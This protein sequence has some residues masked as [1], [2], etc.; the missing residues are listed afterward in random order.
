MPPAPSE[1]GGGRNESGTDDKDAHGVIS[2]FG[3]PQL[4]QLQSSQF[5]PGHSVGRS[6][7]ASPKPGPER[8]EHRNG[9]AKGQFRIG[10][11]K[12][13]G[14]ALGFRKESIISSCGCLVRFVTSRINCP[15][16]TIT[17]EEGL[18]GQRNGEAPAG[19]DP[20]RIELP[21]LPGLPMEW[22]SQFML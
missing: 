16:E 14:A 15:Q 8:D 18:R 3:A 5:V 12:P 7:G 13:Q 2:L 22:K 21:G 9:A 17:S 10:K 4:N 20:G 6:P 1:A 19:T 11:M